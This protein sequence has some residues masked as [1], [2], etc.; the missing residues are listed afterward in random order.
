LDIEMVMMDKTVVLLRSPERFDA[1]RGTL[2]AFLVG[3]A[4]NLILK[5]WC[6]ERRLVRSA[7]RRY[8][9]L[10]NWWNGPFNRFRPFSAGP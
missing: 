6:V 9:K 1:G 10:P 8:R 2:R 5:R 4:R 7:M 3:V